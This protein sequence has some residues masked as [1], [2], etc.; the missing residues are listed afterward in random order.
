MPINFS[1]D[2]IKEEVHQNSIAFC[3]NCNKHICSLCNSNHNE[4]YITNLY[5]LD[6]ALCNSLIDKY[7][8]AKKGYVRILEETK[9]SMIN[10]LINEIYLIQKS[11]DN[12]IK[13]NK[14]IFE[15]L[16]IIK[17]NYLF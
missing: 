10:K 13:R 3:H 7:K 12:C 15:L 4:H 6:D 16:K 11:C 17:N 2:I 14:E 9:N 5:E 8:K 1:C